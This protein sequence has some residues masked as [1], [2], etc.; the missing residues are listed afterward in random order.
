MNQERAVQYRLASADGARFSGNAFWDIA[1]ESKRPLRKTGKNVP[2]E[3][4][5]HP[6]TLH[7]LAC[8]NGT[9]TVAR[10][11]LAKSR[12]LQAVCTDHP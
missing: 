6:E 11:K 10:S 3:T 2:A 12:A 5:F 9:F 8:G 1:R 7:R 4:F